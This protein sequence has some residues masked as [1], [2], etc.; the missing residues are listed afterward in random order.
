[1]LHIFLMAQHFEQ[2]ANKVIRRKNHLRWLQNYVCILIYVLYEHLEVIYYV[3]FDAIARFLILREIVPT[4]EYYPVL[5][6][7]SNVTRS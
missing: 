6:L 3:N 4:G 1:M 2:L 7:P 5:K